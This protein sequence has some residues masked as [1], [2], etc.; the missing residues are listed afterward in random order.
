MHKELLTRILLSQ[1]LARHSARDAV[2]S[3]PQ[4]PPNSCSTCTPGNHETVEGM[5]HVTE[6][7]QVSASGADD[8]MVEEELRGVVKEE[9]CRLLRYWTGREG[10]HETPNADR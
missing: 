10:Q 7:L 1:E 8:K 2:L 5:D 3:E 6:D 4:S 9:L